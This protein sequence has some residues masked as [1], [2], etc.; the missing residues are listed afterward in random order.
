MIPCLLVNEDVK[1]ELLF[2]VEVT[3][4]FS[5]L[6]FENAQKVACVHLEVSS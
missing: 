2:G 5:L 4:V 1:L 6:V 3:Q